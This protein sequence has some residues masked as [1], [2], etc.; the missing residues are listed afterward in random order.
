M[1]K[2]KIIADDLAT[3]ITSGD[4][5]AGTKLPPENDLCATYNVSRI[6]IKKATDRLQQLGLI[7]K[8]RGAGTFVKDIPAAEPTESTLSDVT[9]TGFSKQFEGRHVSTMVHLFE[10]IPAKDEVSE[11][12]HLSDDSFVYHIIRTRSVDRTPLVVEYTYMPIDIVP[13]IT[14]RILQGSIYSHITD[15]L[16]LK[17]QSA[18]R[19]IRALLPTKEEQKLFR[20]R[21]KFA[22]LEVTQIAY[23]SDG[24]IFEYSR[25][26]HRGDK[27]SFQTVSV[28]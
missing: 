13:G 24:R 27:Y 22:I 14:K 8:R 18:H 21:K 5:P 26:H 23:L 12:L 16:N 17:P 25:S 28:Q 6:T 2:Y 4:L 19:T 9:F 7:N 20:T 1:E 10:I 11:A 3:K 15:T